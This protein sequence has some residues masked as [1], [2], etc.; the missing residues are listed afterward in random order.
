[1]KK[2]RGTSLGTLVL[3]T[4]LALSSQAW[5]RNDCSEG[6]LNPQ[7][8]NPHN[9]ANAAPVPFPLKQGLALGEV[10]YKLRDDPNTYTLEQYLA[11]FCTTG[12]L[13]LKEDQIVFE[14]YL[15]GRKPGDSLLSASMSKTIFALLMGIAVKEGKLALDEHISA[16]LPDFKEGAFADDTVEDLLRMSSGAA[17]FN[18]FE[19][20]ADSDNRAVN[21]LIYPRQ[22]IREYLGRKKERAAAPGTVF[23]YNGAQTALLGAALAQRVGG[24]NLTSYLQEKLWIPMGAEAKGYWIKNYH[25][26]EGVQGQFAATLHDFARLGYLVM[27]QGRVNGKEVVPADWIA[28][29]TELRTDRPQPSHPP[30]YGLHIW[31]PQ[32]AGGRAMFW[33]VN[34]QNI[35]VDPVARVVIVH[36]GNG[37]RAEFDGNRHLF[38]LRDAIARSL[39]AP[40]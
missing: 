18:S 39:S 31:I 5:A 22:D 21:P 33:G 11:K 10:S 15:Q 38:A 37:P 30:Y 2:T 4:G 32:A 12:F 6:F 34:G 26:E 9:T 28:K 17:L 23:K 8:G 35:F 29:M 24:K 16:V 3:V 36:T 14:R 20:G 19:P 27:N 40:R 1:M 25:D 7:N 13:V